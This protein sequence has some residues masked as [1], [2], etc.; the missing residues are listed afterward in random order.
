MTQSGVVTALEGENARVAFVRSEACA[1]CRMC[2]FGAQQQV[3]SLMPNRCGAQVGDTV[4]VELHGD[5]VLRA[6]AVAYLIPLAGLLFGL[7]L[8]QRIAPALGFAQKSEL[9][10][11]LFGLLLMAL[12]FLGIRLTEKR[13]SAKALYAP[14]ML[15]V[16]ETPDEEASGPVD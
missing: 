7:A 6:S 14:Q 8:G 11:C 4:L 16:V 15:R 10:A 1:Q 3:E 9:C 12:A 2:D 13:R 5:K